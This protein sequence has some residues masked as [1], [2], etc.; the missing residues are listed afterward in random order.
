MAY[1]I[2]PAQGF[3]RVPEKYPHDAFGVDTGGRARPHS[4]FDLTPTV[5]NASAVP[6][7]SGRVTR[8]GLSQY[9]GNYVEV[10]DSSNRRWLYIHLASISVRPGDSVVEGRTVLGI[11]GN[12]GGNGALGNSKMG[13]HLHVSLAQDATAANRILNGLVRARY[14]NETNAQWATA[15]GLIDPWPVIRDGDKN[16][17]SNTEWLSM[18]DA[19]T[20]IGYLEHL[21]N[22]ERVPNQGYS[23]S[24]AVNNKVDALKNQ[25]TALDSKLTTEV[26]SVGQKVLNANYPPGQGYPWGQALNDRIAELKAIFLAQQPSAKITLSEEEREQFV[27][28]LRE[29]LTPAVAQDLAARLAQPAK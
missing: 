6:A 20:I 24:N 3:P 11:V 28:T 26:Q 16:S 8:T 19:Q 21:I 9:A 29:T 2:A 22:I 10:V 27:E 5:K 15:H 4:G 1:P 18:S 12:T 25:I 23:W 17:N 14:K 13:V 7:V